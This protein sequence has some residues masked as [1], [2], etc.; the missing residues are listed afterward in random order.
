MPGQIFE[1]QNSR[2][3]SSGPDGME[4]TFRY[5]VTGTN[6]DAEIYNLAAAAAPATYRTVPRGQSK[7]SNAGHQT[8]RVEVPYNY[9]VKEQAAGEIGTPPPGS[10]D[11]LPQG[12]PASTP[13]GREYSFSTGGGTV[14]VYHAVAHISDHMRLQD[15]GGNTVNHK[16]A[17]NV[18]KDGTEGVDII[19]PNCEFTVSKRL[20]V[21]SWGYFKTL[22]GMTAKTNKR[23]IGPFKE[24]EV[25][26]LGADGQYKEGDQAPWHLSC[27]FGFIETNA[28][29]INIGDIQI[30]P[31]AKKGWHYLWVEFVDAWNV[32]LEA[33]QRVPYA[34]HIERVYDM[35][36]ME[37]LGMLT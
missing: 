17:I 16:G 2:E 35:D 22:L 14:R 27:R 19:A 24:E 18:T 26:L 31:G 28:K 34:A 37:Q 13:L 23:A 1:L 11:K 33:V 10:E 29:Q 8:W 5:L 15:A 7:V 6:D 4:F 32:A 25:L 20:Q 36:D 21:L 30:Q 12:A 3:F 9:K